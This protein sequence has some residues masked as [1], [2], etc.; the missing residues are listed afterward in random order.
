MK[1]LIIIVL[2]LTSVLF[3]QGQNT[4]R[5]ANQGSIF[6]EDRMLVQAKLTSD[7]EYIAAI[8]Q[9][10]DLKLL[11]T[12]I[13]LWDAQNVILGHNEPIK[14]IELAWET[15][16]D[17]AFSG[18]GNYLAVRQDSKLTIYSVPQLEPYRVMELEAYPIN[19]VATSNTVA[20]STTDLWVMTI[21]Q[22]GKQVIAWNIMT[23][24]RKVYD[25]SYEF[26]LDSGRSKWLP[27]IQ[28][29]NNLWL[30]T[31]F[32]DIS[33]TISHMF[34]VCNRE[35]IQCNNHNADSGA[36]SSFTS[37]LD[38]FVMGF[39]RGKNLI[40]QMISDLR[41]DIVEESD[42][43][44]SISPKGQYLFEQCVEGIENRITDFNT[45]EIIHTIRY[46]NKNTFCHSSFLN[47]PVWFLNE[48]NFIMLDLFTGLKLYEVGIDE[49]I[50]EL[51]FPP[52]PEG[53]SGFGELTRLPIINEEASMILTNMTGFIYLVRI[54]HE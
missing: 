14:S 49:P 44:F 21:D 3:A 46:D 11:A 5:I 28:S 38:Y 22:L 15:H 13:Y 26:V 42:F 35:L 30:I 39:R 54:E 33:E 37:D 1:K 31:D 34:I 52:L 32:L 25:T 45:R 27:Q 17:I 50:Q 53:V 4:P 12:D 2:L 23:D 19:G 6:I 29:V 40:W 24:E 36:I 7:G 47:T 8:A 10:N 20:W 51:T 48:N 43:A 18:D 16:V 9:T 41:F